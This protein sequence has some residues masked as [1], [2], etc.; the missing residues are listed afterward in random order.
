MLIRASEFLMGSVP[1][2]DR[3]AWGAE[4]P[5]HMLNLPDFRLAKT[6]VANQ[7]SE[8][9]VLETEHPPPKDSKYRMPSKGREDPQVVQVSWYDAAAFCR[10]LSEMTCKPYRLPT[11]AEWEKAARGTDGRL[12]P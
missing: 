11:D 2:V 7:K 3:F 8:I 5:Q 10:W 1:E 12:F 4:Q 6:P 9:P